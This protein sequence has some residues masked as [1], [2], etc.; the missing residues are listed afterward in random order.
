MTFSIHC[1]FPA[2]LQNDWVIFSKDDDENTFAPGLSLRVHRDG[3][4]EMRVREHKYRP[5]VRMKTAAG[6]V[7]QGG[8]HHFT[9]SLGYGVPGSPLMGARL[10]SV[11]KTSSPGG[12]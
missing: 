3:S 5:D 7:T 4:V 12:A 10:N 11:S 1:A 2:T 9:V 6:V 8:E